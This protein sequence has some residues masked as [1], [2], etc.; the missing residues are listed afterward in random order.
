MKKISQTFS[1]VDCSLASL[2]ESGVSQVKVVFWG[3]IIITT[4]HNC[5]SSILVKGTAY[6]KFQTNLVFYW[7]KR[8]CVW[9]GGH[10]S[11]DLI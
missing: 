5:E 6:Q 10:K 8:G 3:I 7:K 2:T 11:G 1:I 4:V 9:H